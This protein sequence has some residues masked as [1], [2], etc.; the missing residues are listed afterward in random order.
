MLFVVGQLTGQPTAGDDAAHKI[1]AL[2]LIPGDRIEWR[3]ECGDGGRCP[4]PV[5]AG[6]LAEHM[7]LQA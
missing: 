7:G 2:A 3:C 6:R 4:R 1:T 5:A